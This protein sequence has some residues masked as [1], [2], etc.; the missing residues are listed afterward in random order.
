[1]NSILRPAS[2]WPPAPPRMWFR[3]SIGALR[4][5][6]WRRKSSAAAASFRQTAVATPEAVMEEAKE[7]DEEEDDEEEEEQDAEVEMEG[8]TDFKTLFLFDSSPEIVLC[9]IRWQT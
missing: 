6:I 2:S 9:L 5:T 1:M 4:L 3:R 8:V 7:E